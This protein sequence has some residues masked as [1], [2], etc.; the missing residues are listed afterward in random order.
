MSIDPLKEAPST[1][2]TLGAMRSPT[3]RPAS[4]MW[5]TSVAV[6][7]PTTVPLTIAFWTFT[8]ATTTP[9][10]STTRVLVREMFPSTRPTTFRSSS[11][12]KDPLTRV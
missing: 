9:S 6:M 3:T 5:M 7:L 11:P 2:M 12:L 4:V 1:K 8:S 10:G